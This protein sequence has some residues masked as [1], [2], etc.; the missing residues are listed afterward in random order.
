MSEQ[1]HGQEAKPRLLGLSSPQ[2]PVIQPE[3]AA[4]HCPLLGY[5]A[6]DG[7]PTAAVILHPPAPT[8]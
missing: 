2:S 1:G 8:Y 7:W 4:H 5:L 6:G 3:E